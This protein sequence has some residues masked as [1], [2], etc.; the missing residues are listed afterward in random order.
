MSADIFENL[1]FSSNQWK[2]VLKKLFAIVEIYIYGSLFKFCP[3]PLSGLLLSFNTCFRFLGDLA[4]KTTYSFLG[5]LRS[6]Y[7]KSSYVFIFLL[8]YKRTFSLLNL[9]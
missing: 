9:I 7:F 2:A 1:R 5:P 8:G 4:A 6:R 3:F